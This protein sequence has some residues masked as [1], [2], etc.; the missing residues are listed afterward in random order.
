MALHLLAAGRTFADTGG[1]R[2]PEAWVVSMLQH[3]TFSQ[4]SKW[5]A[6]VL[7]NSSAVEALMRRWRSNLRARLCLSRLS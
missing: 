4:T 6:R 2:R 5:A 7:G 1:V 3:E